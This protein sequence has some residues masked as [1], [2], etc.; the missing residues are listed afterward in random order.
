[1][2]IDNSWDALLRPGAGSDYFDIP[3]LLPIELSPSPV[4]AFEVGSPPRP[5]PVYSRVNAWWFAELSRLIYRKN[6]D[7]DSTRA[8]LPSRADIL[9]DAGH[10]SGLQLRETR[11]FRSTGSDMF[12]SLIKVTD[13]AAH[14][15][16]ILSF[17]GTDS[18]H[19]WFANL[20]ISRGKAVAGAGRVHSGF[21]AGLDTL[22]DTLWPA[23][24]H[25]PHP[26]FL[27]GHSLGAAL[28]ALATARLVHLNKHVHSTYLYGAPRV[29]DAEFARALPRDRVFRIVNRRDLVTE[30]PP[31]VALRF[32]HGGTLIYISSRGRLWFQPSAK[33]LRADRRITPADLSVFINYV[34]TLAPADFVADHAPINYVA[35]MER[36]V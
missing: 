19:D 30:V 21:R 20:R 10:R 34:S 24:E 8:G 31:S 36:F 17:R 3:K 18:P 13:G 6:P 1:M 25:Y 16:A 29:G 14:R 28:A 9:A 26:I 7:E 32:R 15:F 22:W 5:H 12:A 23:V 2:R 11:R 35:Q 33:K 4:G 27:T